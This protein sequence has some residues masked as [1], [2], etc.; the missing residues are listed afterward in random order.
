MIQTALPSAT[1]GP[2]EDGVYLRFII[3]EAGRKGSATG[4]LLA[5][6]YLAHDMTQKW[7]MLV[8]MQVTG[9]EHINRTGTLQLMIWFLDQTKGIMM[10][11]S[12]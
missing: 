4:I 9:I 12:N 8:V 1:S 3:R 10:Q 6:A 2:S 7:I 5:S 11:Q